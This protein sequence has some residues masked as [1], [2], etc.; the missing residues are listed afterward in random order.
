[1]EFHGN[2]KKGFQ[3]PFVLHPCLK[4]SAFDRL[5]GFPFKK[6]KEDDLST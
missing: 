1:M 5:I 6:M 3:A 4:T 2:F